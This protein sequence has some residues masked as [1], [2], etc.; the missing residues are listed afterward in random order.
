M[1]KSSKNILIT[2]GSG[3]IGTNLIK[4][5]IKRYEEVYVLEKSLNRELELLIKENKV[6][7]ISCDITDIGCLLK[8]KTTL[9]KMDVILH[10]AAHVPKTEDTDDLEE[11]IK[12]NL[13]GTI[14]LIKQLKENSKF[15]FISTCEVYG[16]PKNKIIN[17]NHPLDP[18]SYYGASK[19]AAEAFLR[20]YTKKNK[21][22]LTVLRLT[23]V[24][25]PGETINRAVPN[26][27]KAVIKGESPTIYGDGLDK[28]DLI[29]IDDVIAYILVAIE[30]S[31][32]SI[33]NIATGKSHTIKEIAKKIIKL[34]GTKVELKFKSSR[35]IK[36]D[37]IFDV[38]KIKKDLGYVPKTDINEGLLKEIEWFKNAK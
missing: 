20:V 23:N 17:E 34:A 10:L 19:A 35:K 29:Y 12:T 18:L 36:M 31:K 32:N 13:I 5:L 7:L 26:F 2:G 30:K 33:Y 4:E 22:N 16:I 1:K 6:K 3:H 25:G 9:E 37:Y 27:I 38:S 14:N 8:F 24:Y 15:I 28:R 11:A 21:I